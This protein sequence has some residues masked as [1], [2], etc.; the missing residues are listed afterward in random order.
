MD[1]LKHHNINI[2]PNYILYGD[3]MY[4]SGYELTL[5]LLQDEPAVTAIFCANNMMA[6]GALKAISS[7]HMKI[8]DDIS[9]FSY[10]L[11]EPFSTNEEFGI[12]AIELPSALMGEECGKMMVER[13]NN[14]KSKKYHVP[15]RITFDTHMIL[16]GSEIMPSQTK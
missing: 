14:R 12:S 6:K 10:G 7:A 4:E 16:K 5:R 15:R 8:P 13:L 1:S 11:I 3:F 9:L 2:N